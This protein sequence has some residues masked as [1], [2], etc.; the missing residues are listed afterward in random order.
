MQI[1]YDHSRNLHTLVGAGAA[2][3]TILQHAKPASL[4]D[5]GCGS[6]TWLKAAQD[7]GISDVFGIDGID[8]SGREFLV[9][10]TH[11]KEVNLEQCWNLGRRF[12][13]VLCLEVAEH[14][15][16]EVS[17]AL[18]RCLVTHGDRIYFGAACPG[19]EGQHHVNC[20]WPAY[21]QALFNEAG[22]RCEDSVRWAL[23]EDK[24][25][26][27][28][29]RQNMFLAIRDEQTAGK[30]SRIPGVIHPSMFDNNA[31]PSRSV[32]R[33][34]VLEQVEGG[35]EPIPWYLALPMKA[36]RGKIVRRVSRAESNKA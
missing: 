34:Q 5:V 31:I 35:S 24:R 30:E 27:P 12:E 13:V 10:Q 25:I 4:L 36:A 21:W 16:P 8:T 7:L 26:E 18:I 1:D 15:E 14:L 29:Y 11:F 19:Q 32:Y 9:S 3:G 22:F 33:R 20:Q 23:W 6:G 17:N 2:L 28:W